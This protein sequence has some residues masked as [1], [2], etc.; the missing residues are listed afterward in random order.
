MRVEVIMYDQTYIDELMAKAINGDE[1]ACFELGCRY[2]DGNKVG[3][4]FKE[5]CRWLSKASRLGSSEARI[6]LDQIEKKLEFQRKLKWFFAALSLVFSVIDQTAVN[7]DW[8]FLALSII[9]GVLAFFFWVLSSR[10]Q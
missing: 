8:D 6:K 3:K 7:S 5:A 9:C 2:L 4:S 10:W 1:K